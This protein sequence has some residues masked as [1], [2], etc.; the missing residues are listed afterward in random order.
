YASTAS[1]R[2]PDHAAEVTF[3]ASG[4]KVTA[5]A[6]QTILQA[7]LEAGIDLPFSCTMGGC[8]ACK[9]K[10]QSGTVV[11]SEPNCLSETEREAGHVLACCAYADT[12]VV[13]ENH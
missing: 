11:M 4:R 9:A 6:G 8:G 13:I 10:K 7:G 1:V 5:R 2:I 3:A 12:N